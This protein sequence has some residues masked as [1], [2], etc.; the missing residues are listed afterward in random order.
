V[1]PVAERIAAF[2][3]DVAPQGTPAIDQSTGQRDV[4]AILAR[5]SASL[6]DKIG[7]MAD[8]QAE[9][10]GIAKAFAESD[11]I[12]AAV[13]SAPAFL[14]TAPGEPAPPGIASYR[15][16]IAKIE[17]EGSGG[18]SAVGVRDPELGRPLGRYQVMEAN[19]GPWSKA[20][21]GREV[22]A[23]EFL[24]DPALQDAVF[25]HRFGGYVQ[26]Y[27][28][29]EDA[30]SAWFTGRPLAEGA[31]ARDALGT[32]GADYVSRFTAEL[33]RPA[34]PAPRPVAAPVHLARPPATPAPAL[35]L[36]NDGTIFGD[37]HDRAALDIFLD[38]LDTSSR[39]AMWALAEQHRDRPAELAQALDAY[40]E[41][42]KGTLPA[43]VRPTF[44]GTFQRERLSL[45]RE[46]SA[47]FQR[48]QAEE[49]QAAFEE[50]LATR[51]TALAR[52][53]TRAGTDPVADKA[54]AAEMEDFARF[55]GA[56]TG[57]KPA[58][59]GEV[60]RAV[61]SDVATGRVMGAFEAAPTPERRA[62]LAAAFTQ[63]WTDGAAEAAGID[64]EAYER[65]TAAME[66]RLAQ[67]VTARDRQARVLERSV[68]GVME[69]VKKGFDVPPAERTA[70]K[71]SV[72]ASGAPEVVEA[73]RWFETLSDW[74]L[75]HRGA[76]PDAVAAQ[77]AALEADMREKGAT[78]RGLA[79]L[80]VMAGL[81]RTIE[82][83]LKDDPLA[84]AERVGRLT[85]TPL[86]TSTPAAFRASL[87][88]RAAE[89]DAVADFY[90]T[91]K[92]FFRKAEVAALRQQAGENPE[93]L[94]AF[95]RDLE[96]L[97]RDTPRALAEISKEAPVIAHA[98]GI[99]VAT[100]D[101][102]VLSDTAQ[103]LGLRKIEGYEPLALKPEGKRAA[104]ADALGP[105]MMATPATEAAAIAHADLLFELRARAA[106]VDPAADPDSAAELYAG[107]LNDALGAHQVDG[108]QYGGLTSVNG[109]PAVAPSWLR[110]DTL[111]GLVQSLD[112]LDLADLPPIWSANGQPIT[113]A[114]LAGG[115]LLALGDG[116]YHLALG[117]PAS[118]DAQLVMANPAQPW[119]LDLRRLGRLA[120][121]GAADLPYRP[122]IGRGRYQ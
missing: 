114:R 96:V 104:V 68:D 67:D 8:R 120:A 13:P 50:S 113:P 65:I 40:A 110:A 20:A 84:H 17:S 30:A 43:R 5:S 103:A 47:G 119:V 37:A 90:G 101:D 58:D 75:K 1:A 31:N 109:S 85:V 57:M 28:N 6:A 70:L 14:P 44:E 60:L 83:G 66:R 19:V 100:R 121:S 18:Y 29:A 118:G 62:E 53:A 7:A 16:A 34:A 89:A 56:H 26:E 82:R 105:A 25:D 12:A 76:R 87:S 27:G 112:D 33:G 106:G 102:T 35:K 52:L 116:R 122:S 54:L 15:D 91:P 115:K 49:A 45:L 98:A 88:A 107:A 11:A 32:S 73:F 80:D 21:V 42:V 63:A 22:T 95:A 39:T 94:L 3:L 79:A 59:R 93:F 92:R 36:Y 23:A 108:A 97:G 117:D 99:A 24:A 2:G 55:V 10:R 71:A 46:A 86:D 9:R 74:Q 72:E 4:F 78:E 51:R 61:Q 48:R 38:R 69:R 41:G 81:Q 77:V 64:V 111:E